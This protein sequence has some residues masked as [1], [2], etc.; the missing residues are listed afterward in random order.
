LNAKTTW[1]IGSVES[2][3]PS[4]PKVR[5]RLAV[6]KIT[7]ISYGE[8]ESHKLTEVGAKDMYHVV[9]NGF[10]ALEDLVGQVEIERKRAG[11]NL[12]MSAKESLGYYE[13]NQ[14]KPWFDKEYSKLFD[15][16]KQDKLRW[17]QDP[18]DING[19][20]LDNVRHQAS[21]HFRN[22]K[23]EYLKGKINE[24]ATNSKNKNIRDLYREINEFNRGYQ[25]RSNLVKDEN[26]DLLAESHN[27]LNRWKK[28]LSQLLNVRNV[29]DVQLVFLHSMLWLLVTANIPSSP[30]VVTLMMEAVRFSETSVFVRTARCHIPEEGILF[31]Q[32]SFLLFERGIQGPGY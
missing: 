17:L 27:I 9:S 1:V 24:L 18:D 26:G 2:F 3:L 6:I 20:N 16:R 23:R 14:H 10:A 30:I 22:K 4:I 7:Q 15:Q 19:D 8:V 29:S 5:K 32:Y 31:T 13:L 11:E 28:Y 21:R 12:K 25:P